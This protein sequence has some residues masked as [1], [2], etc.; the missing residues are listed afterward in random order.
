MCPG[1]CLILCL[2]GI[3][4]VDFATL[5]LFYCYQ[6]YW[7]VRAAKA[8]AGA[9]LILVGAQRTIVGAHLNIHTQW[10]I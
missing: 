3:W 2:Y 8:A 5:L 9:L 4:N 1:H 10:R 7:C 6:N